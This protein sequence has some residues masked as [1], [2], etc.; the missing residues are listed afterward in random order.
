MSRKRTTHLISAHESGIKLEKAQQW[1][2]PVIGLEWL[3]A[4]ARSG[5][6]QPVA[7]FAKVAARVGESQ[8]CREAQFLTRY[9][10]QLARLHLLPSA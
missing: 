5:V 4:T 6:I 1:G 8:V 3:H 2:I 7:E 10:M 9:Q